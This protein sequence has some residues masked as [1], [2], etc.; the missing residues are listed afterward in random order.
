M[1]SGHPSESFSETLEQN[2]C[3]VSSSSPDY[4]FIVFWC[5]QKKLIRYNAFLA[6]FLL[7]LTMQPADVL[8]F[9]PPP[10][11]VVAC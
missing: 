9:A 6:M 3:V 1:I 10:E 4:S 5:D 7:L 11:R 2:R 8:V